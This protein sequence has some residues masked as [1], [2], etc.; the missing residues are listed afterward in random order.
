ML[1]DVYK[2]IINKLYTESEKLEASGILKIDEEWNLR[3]NY[4]GYITFDFA[5]KEGGY[6]CS[7]VVCDG[8]AS[9]VQLI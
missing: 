4:K 6:A 1:E 9:N 2:E 5:T 7:L 3:E 8:V